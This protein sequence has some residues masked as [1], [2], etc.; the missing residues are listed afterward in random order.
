MAGL[1]GRVLVTGATAALASALTALA[2]SRIERGRATPPLN[3][4]SHIAWAGEPP[5]EVGPKGINFATRVALHAGASLF[6]A[7]SLELPF[8]RIARRS[9]A[10][11]WLGGAIVSAVAFV[12]DYY[13]VSRRF[14]P[15]YEAYL[16]RRGLLAVYAA[17][18][19]GLALGARSTRLDDHDPEN[20]DERD[21][22][23]HAKPSPDRVIRYSRIGRG[24]SN[25]RNQ[26]IPGSCSWYSR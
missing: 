7:T 16:S 8:G 25:E 20:G 3:A 23:G 15:G 18:A 2:W 13:L 9:R 10:A 6:W 14:Q 21:E 11:A 12:T 24:E 5:A 19:A 26:L 22:R 1:V 17:I 4:V